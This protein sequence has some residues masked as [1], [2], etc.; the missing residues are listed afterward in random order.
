MNCKKK[1]TLLLSA[2]ALSIALMLPGADTSYAASG[3]DFNVNTG[4]TMSDDITTEFTVK[5]GN[6][7]FSTGKA[8]IDD[9]GVTATFVKQADRNKGASYLS[10]NGN[11]Q[12][13]YG[14]TNDMFYGNPD[15]GS[16]PALGMN[17]QPSNGCGGPLGS[18]KKYNAD[19][20]YEVG[21]VT[22]KFDKKVTDPIL[23]LSGLGG[24]VSRV[25]SYLSNGR[26]ILVGL[27][28]FNSTN[29]HLATE[30]ITLEPLT[31]NSNLTADNNIIQVKDRNTHTRAV[32]DNDGYNWI[33]FKDAYGN[34]YNVNSPALAPAGTGSVKLKGTFDEVTF[35]LYHQATPYSKFSQAK[36]NT[37]SSYFANQI[38]GDPANGDGI[39]GMNVI[40]T[41]SVHI[42]GE[43]FK[44]DQ[45]WD[46]FRA[47]LR[48][49]KPSSIGDKVWLDQDKDGIQ[50]ATE[51]PAVGVT[52]KL[53]DKDGNP[54]KDFNG[55]PVADQVT[56]ENGNYKFENLAAGD[57]IVEIVPNKGQ[58]LTIK[59]AGTNAT[60]DS[61]FDITTNKTETITIE[62]NKH[63]TDID[64]GLVEEDTYKVVYKFEPKDDGVTPK[65]LPEEVMAQLPKPVEEKAD[66]E[67]VDSPKAGTFNNVETDEGTWSFEK[68]D[69]DSVT[70]DKDTIG[71]DR[72]EEVTGY[73][74]FTPKAKEYKVTHEFKSGTP[75]K[76]LPEEVKKL[77]PADKDG[78]KDGSTVGPTQPTQTKVEVTDGIWEF[79][80]YDRQEATITGKDE[81]FV[82][83]WEFTPK[84][85][86]GN[87]YVKYVTED[88]EVLEAEST[89]KKDAK[90]GEAYTTEEKTFDGYEFVKLE[91]GSAPADGEVKKGDQHV[92]YVYKKK[93]TPPAEE[94]GNVYVKYVTED[95][96]VLEEESVV[97]K[98]AKVGEAYTTEEKT[99]DGYE[100]VKL[101]DGSAPADGKVEK[102]DQHVT[103]VYKKK[104]YKVTHEFKS[105]T[106]GKEL[107]NEVKI[108]KPTDQEGKK[109]GEKVTPT[110]PSKTEVPVEGGKWVFK[111]Y[112]KKD[113][114]IDK[115]DEHFVGTWVF[116]EDKT[117]EPEK[118]YKV[119]H[120]FKSGTTGKEL[121]EEVNKLRP[122]DQTG[123]KDGEK[124]TPTQPEKT[125]VPVE[126]G[127]WVFKNYDKKDSAIDKANEHFVGT[128]VFTPDAEVVTEYVDEDGN[129]ISDKENGT[130]DKK[131]IEGYEFVRTEKDEK[132]NTKHI[133]KKKT[134][135]S[136]SVVT[137][138]VDEN[139]NP[140]AKDEDG[141]Q[142]KKDIPAYEFV[143]TINDKDGNVVHVYRFKQ[144][145]SSTV[146][147]RYVDTEGNQILADKSGTHDPS[148]IEGYQFV[149]TEKD[150][151]GNTVHIYQKLA[152]V[153]EVETRYVD[154]NGNQLLPPKEGEQ[155]SVA[156][157]GYNYIRTSKDNNGNTIHTYSK[158]PFEDVETRYVDTEGNQILADKAGENPAS[159]IEGYQ[160]VR[161]EKDDK[162]NI[163]HIYQKTAPTVKVETRYIDENG[164]QLL[165][166]KEGTQNQVNIE[167]YVYVS[168]NNDN[169][170]NTIHIYKK[171]ITPIED[172]VTKYVDE[173]GNEIAQTQKG[174]NPSKN[175]EGYEIITT[176][177]DD[178]GNIIYVYRKKPDSTKVV[179]K[180]VDEK[181]NTIAES[182]DGKKPNKDIKGYEFV[183]TETD[184]DGNTVHIYKKK[185]TPPTEVVTE[186]V[187]ENG[188]TIAPKENGTK[189]KKDIKGY[190]FVKTEKD[191]K[192]N[193]K[194]IYKKKTTPTQPAE[195]KYKVTHKFESTTPGKTLPKEIL[196]LLPKNQEGIENGTKVSPRKP[197]KLEVK[198]KDGTWVFE[199]YDK[200][201]STID[202]KDVNFTGKWKFVP[203]KIEKVKVSTGTNSVDKSNVKTGKP[204]ANTGK[205][206][207]NTGVKGYSNIVFVL[208]GSVFALYKIKKNK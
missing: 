37:H 204:N 126:G 163:T 67:T 91:D 137:K 165:P 125:E 94:T 185:T 92:T 38:G 44:G 130:K 71:E 95:G 29:L 78:N 171:V 201:S 188:K 150:E 53:L 19:G 49:P 77:T 79:K 124:V 2:S 25:G 8:S 36:Y 121:P 57:Y 51:K 198:V 69:N 110:K 70:I 98:D 168:T 103:Y 183:K 191:E 15:P 114:A 123:K 104:E 117:P 152:P 24:Y 153:P 194:H 40:N 62:P 190:E 131:D 16:I 193:T 173:N 33:Q 96:K 42:G 144:T 12:A 169:N 147:T 17:T 157:D 128:W 208:I 61:D 43:W 90:V 106:P 119:T 30:G 159:T 14:A 76:D 97:K 145:P 27:G 141:K 89:V 122:A 148:T 59:G 132:G 74:K 20:E 4:W 11:N 84:E 26:M 105:G 175:I 177:T 179:T 86:T 68:W 99:F 65:E 129:T 41:E 140:L 112:D 195:N 189:D 133:Y 52:V 34:Q 134:T 203:N 207:V 83:T 18:W 196:D 66:G 187:D 116:E 127:K 10:A 115:A 47:S 32:V 75:D 199:G 111:N 164:N 162:G 135:P 120:E 172:V 158:T 181:G 73:W 63:L 35:K 3:N 136:P 170:G 56:D 58:K 31:S 139:G 184:K 46:L 109:D 72:T 142:D 167:G 154:E 200:N 21:S 23:D 118:E 5:N 81:N 176:K 197:S 107:P 39:N 50:G 54:V 9:I 206:N 88:G 166:P 85:E 155:G 87:V 100:F 192:G 202:N 60:A 146:E 7:A 93:E 22:F 64:A 48:L 143:K 6:K 102:G 13:A 1:F 178:K 161:T 186:Y 160:F 149:R 28:S 151:K 45:N 101:E 174:K 55:N 205:L 182:E 180:F 82:G 108:L 138:F 156:I 80:G 113:S